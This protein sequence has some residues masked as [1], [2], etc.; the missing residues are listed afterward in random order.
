MAISVRTIVFET[1][2]STWDGVADA[3]NAVIFRKDAEPIMTIRIAAFERA[4][5]GDAFRDIN[6]SWIKRHFEVEPKD[7]EVLNDPEGAILAPGGAILIAEEAEG[8]AL[9]AVALIKMTDGGY[10][11]AKMGVIEEAQGRGIGRLLMEAAIAEARARRAP[12]LYI[13]TNAK[14]APA[15][16]LYESVGFRALG[17]ENAPSSPYRRCDVQMELRLDAVRAAG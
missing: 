13:E 2:A 1:P 6:L 12:R 8:R 5:H 11:L 7:L 15:I 14:L 4:R 10:E 17:R 3:G 9:G 16:A